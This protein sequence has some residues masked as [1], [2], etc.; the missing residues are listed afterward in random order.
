MTKETAATVERLDFSKPPPGYTASGQ[1]WSHPRD[2]PSRV[3]FL[4]GQRDTSNVAK[5]SA[6]D[7]LADAW[8]H[9]CDTESLVEPPLWGWT[10]GERDQVT[11]GAWPRCLTWPDDQVA[12]VERWLA[13]GSSEM[14]EVLRG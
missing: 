12:E 14:P 1:W 10:E 8:T 11:G 2:E 9:H 3:V 7:A 6:T 5:V 4:G 13:D